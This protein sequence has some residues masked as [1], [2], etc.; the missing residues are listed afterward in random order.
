MKIVHKPK[1]PDVKVITSSNIRKT[2]MLSQ[3]IAYLSALVMLALS[4][5]AAIATSSPRVTVF[6]Q[7]GYAA[8]YQVN[9]SVNGQR[10]ELKVSGVVLGG[11]RTLTLPLG[12]QN[13]TVK[14]QMLTGLLR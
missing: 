10:R 5:T 3:K 2:N 1:I 9:Y 4:G 6:N 13:I 7:G 11:K 12:S 14:G 8:D